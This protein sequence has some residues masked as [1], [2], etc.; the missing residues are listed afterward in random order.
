MIIILVVIVM[1]VILIIVS[2]LLINYF[3]PWLFVM[4]TDLKPSTNWHFVI[5]AYRENLDWVHEFANTFKNKPK[6]II[7]SKHVET[8]NNAT[9]LPNVGRCDHTYLHHIIEH[10]GNLPDVILFA[11]GS[12][13]CIPRK[14]YTLNS[15]IKPRLGSKKFQCL[16]KGLICISDFQIE[17]Y[18]AGDK[19]NQENEE[20]CIKSDIRPFG[21][22]FSSR[23][24]NR[25]PPIVGV[26]GG[27][28]A[29]TKKAILN[30]PLEVWKGLLDEHSIGDNLEVGHF[31]ERSWYALLTS[32]TQ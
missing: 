25:K 17:N 26:C 22:W 12:T 9:Q 31:M 24:R 5:S 2:C 30:V 8:S 28:F 6:I 3:E 11:T 16:G 7:Y 19:R 20:K 13:N 27:V 18:L 32:K 10:Y 1:L 15:I 14:K 29:T 4:P 21:K 23:F